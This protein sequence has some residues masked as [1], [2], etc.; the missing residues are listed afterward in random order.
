ML[1]SKNIALFIFLL[2]PF[3]SFGE[4]MTGDSIFVK[5]PRKISIGGRIVDIKRD[6]IIHVSDSLEFLFVK[7]N[8]KLLK[9]MDKKNSN[10]VTEHLKTW[11][12]A[13][14]PDTNQMD[15]G[16]REYLNNFKGK[17]VR[18]VK[19]EN[20]DVFGATLTSRVPEDERNWLERTGN[21][22]HKNT[23]KTLIYKTLNIK[24]GD[25]IAPFELSEKEVVIRNLP[26]ISD[27][28]I[29]PHFVPNSDSVDLEVFVQDVW[30]L[31]FHL[32]PQD[33]Y[34]GYFEVYDENAF[35]Q[36]QEI[37]FRMRYNA[38]RSPGMGT[39]AY[40][41]INNIGSEI[42][43]TRF[44]YSSYFGFRD[45]RYEMQKDYYF[46][47]NY[48]FGVLAQDYSNLVHFTLDNRDA[49]IKATVSDFW[50]GKGFP[51]VANK[52]FDIT[53]L[54]IY[55]ATR[56]G[57]YHFSGERE[58]QVGR[59][60]ALHNRRF[61]LSS[62]AIAKQWYRQTKLLLGYGRTEDVPYGYKL[63]LVGGTEIGEFRNRAYMAVKT[64]A[65]DFFSLGYCSGYLELGSFLKNDSLQQGVLKT[66]LFYYSNLVRF[67][68]Y[69]FRQFIGVDYTSG[70]N[71]F[72]GYGE[73][74]F[75]R[76]TNGIRGFTSDSVQST[77]RA[78][79][80]FET[81]CYSP[82]TLW[83][84]KMALFAYSDFAWINHFS[85]NIFNGPIYYGLGVGVRIRNERLAFKT[86]SIRLAIY[87]NIPKGGSYEFLDISGA[88]RLSL[89]GF[90]PSKPDVVIYE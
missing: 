25:E 24:K 16:R 29:T 37:L 42:I 70:F 12:F 50:I 88:D 15:L 31:G 82:H 78:F 5:A 7:Q 33:T 80:R 40:Y 71:R 89:S 26:Y 56:V 81:V 10:I 35:G 86:F 59:N 79:A 8:R 62:V 84:F 63:E 34:K 36:G 14:K 18:N 1:T 66:G 32:E 85:N 58:V 21:R 20:V 11:L 67:G 69:R 13:G 72:D 61:Y 28:M 19:V 22:I 55:L 38:R 9:G 51:L 47:S 6:T 39:E 73:R 4:S 49:Q 52:R 75:L 53:N 83:G 57:N 45:V 2:L 3:C 17:I 48:A 41:T 87:P 90:K 27:V 44:G 54:Q 77:K 43:K 30:S 76:S 64:A 46:K 60:N 68:T 74:I 23:S 65:G